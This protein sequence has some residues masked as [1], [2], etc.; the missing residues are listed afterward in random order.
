MT[1]TALTISHNEV[2]SEV[3]QTESH[4]SAGTG[5]ICNCFVQLENLDER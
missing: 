3:K 1:L 5:S 4:I 2:D